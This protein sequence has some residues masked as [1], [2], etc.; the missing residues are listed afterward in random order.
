[1]L[2][3]VA[4]KRLQAIKEFT[5]LGSGFKIA[6]RD[7]TIR[8]AGNLL[9]AQQH[10]FIESVG[11]DLYSQML[12]EAIEERKGDKPKEPP[13][14]VEMD[15]KVDAYIP[16]SYIQDAKQK[17]EMYKRFKGCETIEDLADLKDE[18]FDRFGEYP[19]QVEY[20]LRLTE[21]KLRANKE[22]VES[23]VEAKNQI[24]ILFSPE[25]S[26]EMDGAMLFEMAHSLGREVTLG[27]SGEKIK[28]VIK[29][30]NIGDEEL[31]SK[32]ESILQS[33][34]KSRK[35]TTSNTV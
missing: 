11:F 28:F 25:T 2:T 6:M 23:I 7:L 5:E 30:K 27:T 24:D 29:T 15:I 22:R 20:L 19:K 12:K 1:V 10:G 21:I 35:Q 16:E 18:M 31:I 9:G 26:K 3:E 33:I 4:E 13:F 17:I 14:Q 34:P 8:G 32:V